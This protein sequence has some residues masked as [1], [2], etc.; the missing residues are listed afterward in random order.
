MIDVWINN[1]SG[2]NVESIESQYINISTYRPLSG[3]S[4]INLPVELKSPRKGLINIKDKDQ[5]CFC[6]VMLDILILQKKILKEF[7]KLKKKIDEK[8]D[9]DRIEFPV[10]EKGFSKIE[11]KNNICIDVFGYENGL[12]FTIYVSYK[13]FEDSM[14]LLFLVDN[15]KPHYMCIKDFDRFMFLKTKNKN[16]KWF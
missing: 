8:L 3:S 2:W 10:Q 9:Y 14:G 13:K 4:Y 12:V 5:K 15:E 11:V 6:G 16:K 1:G 7:K